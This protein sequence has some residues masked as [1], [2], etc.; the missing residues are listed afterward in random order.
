MMTMRSSK[1]SE[2]QI[3]AALFKWLAAVHPKVVAYAIPNAARR[4]MAQAAYLKAEGLRAGMPDVVIATAR[5]GYHGMYLELKTQKG[6]LFESQTEMLTRLA[7]EGYASAV[8]YGL[9]D[10]IFLITKY[11]EGKWNDLL[12]LGTKH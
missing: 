2:H 11:V 12:E 6:K 8:A 1:P 5:G 9:D 10:A 4:S 3:Q 7:N